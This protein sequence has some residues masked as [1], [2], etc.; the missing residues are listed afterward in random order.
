M[1]KL[2]AP[3][4]GGALRPLLVPAPERTEALARAATLRP[5]PLSSREVSDAL[6]LGMGAY[7]P[8]DGFMGHDD[9]QRVCREMRLASGVFWPIPITMSL[10]SDMAEALRPGEEVALL[11]SGTGPGQAGH[12]V[13]TLRITEKYRIDQRLECE[14]VFRTVDP[15]HPGV[16]K[17]LAQ[18]EVNIAGPVRVL[19][20][21]A[22]PTKYP[23][24]YMRPEE[25][26][27]EFLRRGWREVA[28]FQTR[29]P[30]HRSHEHLAKIAIEVLE[31]EL[32]AAPVEEPLGTPAAYPSPP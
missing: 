32:K 21:G 11:D 16:E 1:S 28:A 2:V 15:K 7:T 6:M 14:S 22:Y 20:E 5:L 10:R 25:A 3:H 19:T 30:M 12:I 26:R 8:L 29:N 27:A 24:L 31:R 9:W 17:V 18:P 13:G 23:G 4:G